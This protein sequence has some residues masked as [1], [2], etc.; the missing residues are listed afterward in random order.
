MVLLVTEMRVVE[1]WTV[2]GSYSR[3]PVMMMMATLICSDVVVRELR[4]RLLL[5]RVVVVKASGRCSRWPRLQLFHP[6]VALPLHSSVLEPD[7]DLSLAE[8]QL[9]GELG[10][11]STSQVAV[12]VELFLELESLV[13]RVRRTSSL[14]VATLTATICS[15]IN[16]VSII[17]NVYL[18]YFRLH[19]NP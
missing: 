1:C 7:L 18:R 6:V 17:T 10:A 15:R 8:L 3:C 2:C 14:R 13:S 12:E 11:P 9:F 16:P 4:R 19:F 5:K